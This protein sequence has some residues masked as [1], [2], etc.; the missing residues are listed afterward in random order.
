[1]STARTVSS[2]RSVSSGTD[3]VNRGGEGSDAIMA[4]V[5]PHGERVRLCQVAKLDGTTTRAAG[6]GDGA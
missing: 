1:M 6:G 4:V 2:G 5:L 3:G